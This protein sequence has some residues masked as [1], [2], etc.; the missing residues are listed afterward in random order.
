MIGPLSNYL[1]SPMALLINKNDFKEYRQLSKGRD[2]ELIESYIQEAQEFDLKN[3][4]CRTF[5]FDLINN[6]QQPAYQALIHGETYTDADG[7]SIEFKGL[8]AVIVYYAYSRYVMQSSAIDTP[9]GMVQKTTEFSQPVSL[10]EKRDISDRA[11]ISAA[12]Y[13][14]ECKLY[15][16]KKSD[17]FPK[18]KECSDCGCDGS[19]SA[20][21]RKFKTSVL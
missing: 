17:T 18:W 2:V 4:L 20:G 9:F 8:K 13:W 21:S 11:A 19:T 1:L 6:Y 3:L 7:N 16:D 10:S 15:L 5:Y 12:A 14:E